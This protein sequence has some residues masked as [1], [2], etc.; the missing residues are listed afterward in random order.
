MKFFKTLHWRLMLVLFVLV[1]MLMIMIIGLLL[2]FATKK[3]KET[4]NAEMNK[5]KQEI[6]ALKGENTE[7][8]EGAEMSIESIQAQIDALKKEAEEKN[9]K[10][11]AFYIR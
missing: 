10:K 5:I 7:S 6:A 2:F 11:K 8:A 9:K 3:E 4:D 1:I